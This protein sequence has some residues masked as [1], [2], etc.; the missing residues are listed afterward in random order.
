[1]KNKYFYRSQ[2]S[3]A[4]FREIIQHFVSEI[5]ASKTALLCR[6]KE[7]LFLNS[8]DPWYY[9]EVIEENRL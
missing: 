9:S 7:N 5:N 1:M 2:I 6:D 4:K 3:K 8:R